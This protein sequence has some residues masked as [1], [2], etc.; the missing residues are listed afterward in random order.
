MPPNPFEPLSLRG[1]TLKNRFVAAPMATQYA[2]KR[3]LVT[4]TMLAYYRHL[5]LTGVGMVVAEAAVI[6][7]EGPG[8][9]RELNAYS[10]EALP[11][12]RQLAETIRERGAIPLLQL[13]HAGR[14][15]LPSR[16]HTQMVAPS[17]IPCPVLDRPVR[18]LHPQEI[19]D[20]VR[21][22]TDSARLAREAGFAGVELH[23]AHGYLLH[24]FVSPLTNQRDDE[25]GL[26]RH[27]A[28]RFPLEVVQS[29]RRA[30]PDL[31]ISYRLSARDYLPRGLTLQ[32]SC[33]LAKGLEG[34]GADLISVSG[35]MYA[36]LHGPE[37]LVGPATPYG[38]FRDDARDIREAVSI[39]VAVAGKIQ[40]PTL[41]HEIIANRDAHLIV[42]GRMLLRDPAWIQKAQGLD[43]DPVRACL[44]C[45][46][47]RFHSRGCPDGA[48][49][50]TWN[51]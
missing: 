27:A 24:Q 7:P 6:S 21:K 33:L 14:Q 30:F 34:A 18:A 32:A 51:E 41:A 37:S 3:G 38:V 16:E 9:S 10:E 45:P 12:L 1:Y 44:L 15:G 36:S 11:G 2:D 13:H 31:I 28:S 20:L 40:Y 43:R 22:F 19:K 17:P 26:Q 42:L 49:R 48:S 46:R 23:G 29:I 5:T 4:E 25:Y 39:P 50:P 8:W 47:C 35:G